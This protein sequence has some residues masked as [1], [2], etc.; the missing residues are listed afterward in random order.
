MLF[1]ECVL[2]FLMHCE[3]RLPE[4]PLGAVPPLRGGER[5]GGRHAGVLRAGSGAYGRRV[6]A[7]ADSSAHRHDRSEGRHRIR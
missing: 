3:P 5:G 4:A 2:R 6:R 7:R 1:I